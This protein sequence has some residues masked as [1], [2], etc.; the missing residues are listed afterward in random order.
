MPDEK[1]DDLKA[2]EDALGKPVLP[3]LTVNVWKVRTNLIIASSISIAVALAD[4]R[5]DPGST[6]LG[7][8][9]FGLTDNLV[10]ALLL[11]ITGYLLI[12]FL[13]S[14]LD[15]FLEWR[16]R[17]TGTRLAF[18]TAGTFA[19]EHADY[20]NDPRQSTLY[21]WW[22]LEA[23]RIGNMSYNLKILQDLIENLDHDLREKYT[24][25]ADALNIA[26]NACRPL[27][28]AREAIHKLERSIG[29][30]A[31]TIKAARI[32]GSLKRFDNW[33]HLFLRSQNLRWLV[34]DV[35][36][37]VGLAGIALYLLKTA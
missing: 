27:A 21:S 3:E 30:A 1:N 32:P 12:H 8:K 26:N 11:I 13:W 23:Q 10:R 25:G 33:F 22:V 34:I 19:K 17:I 36:V 31:K 5:I 24:S 14:A 15:A 18:V 7:L 29:E 28:E 2:V 35:L 4:L 20:P 16:L 9:F 6:F 37:P